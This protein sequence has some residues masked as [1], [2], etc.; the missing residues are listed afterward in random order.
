MSA[1]CAHDRENLGVF[2]TIGHS[3]AYTG[4]ATPPQCWTASCS[5]PA[6]SPKATQGPEL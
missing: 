3:L 6:P 1:Q 5:T 4:H 2:A